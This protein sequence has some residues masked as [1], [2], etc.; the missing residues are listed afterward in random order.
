MAQCTVQLD[1]TFV[2]TICP[3][4]SDAKESKYIV[5]GSTGLSTVVHRDGDLILESFQKTDE[6]VWKLTPL[7]DPDKLISVTAR[8]SVHAVYILSLSSQSNLELCASSPVNC[9]ESM[10]SSIAIGT[11]NDIS[12]YRDTKLGATIPNPNT[13]AIAF[14]SETVVAASSSRSLRLIDLRT[15][16]PSSENRGA[17]LFEISALCA[18]GADRIVSG[19]REGLLKFWDA[20]NISSP[21]LTLTGGHRHW[22]TGLRVNATQHLI[23]AGT[24]CAVNLWQPPSVWGGRPEDGI[25][26]RGVNVHAD[27]VYDLNW[28]VFN[29]REF[30]SVS[31]DG[32]VAAWSVKT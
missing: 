24:C 23:S 13:S 32:L 4:R 17:H 11:Q 9:V 19:C 31:F 15:G 1:D 28:S 7:S 20:R 8:G 12:I 18:A 26:L 27:S 14:L 3:I 5:G 29:S 6:A 10:N 25:L 30:A 2:R 21:V 16:K 22:V